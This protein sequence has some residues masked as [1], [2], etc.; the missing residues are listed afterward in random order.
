MSGM[1]RTAGKLAAMGAVCGVLLGAGASTA[2]AGSVM[3]PGETIGLALG[4]PLPEGVYFVD[5]F[6]W[7]VRTTHP[8][9]ALGVNIPVIAWSTPWTIL[10]GR[11]E[12]LGAWPELES[13]T[14]G[15]PTFGGVNNGSFNASMYN[16]IILGMIAWDLGNGFG[17]SYGIGNYFDVGYPLSWSTNSLRQDFSVSYTADGWN[18][19]ATAG[20]GISLDHFAEGRGQISPCTDPTTGQFGGCNP[21]WLNLDLTATKKFDKWELGPVAFGSWDLSSPI[22]GYARQEQFAAGGLVGYNF[23]PLDLQVYVTTTVWQRNYGGNDTRG[24]FRITVPLW[25]PEQTAE[26]IPVK[27]PRLQ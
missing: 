18:L 25:T 7:G 11:F 1:V 3:Q 12:L 27:A 15:G 13:G 6:D 20:L 9:T 21:N 16:P 4:A 17:V 2:L 14:F 23:G 10:G 24:W 26:A 8:R 5:T 19:S 22:V